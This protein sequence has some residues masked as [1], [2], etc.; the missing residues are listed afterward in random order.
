MGEGITLGITLGSV[1]PPDER[2]V[3]GQKG[4]PPQ[5]VWLGDFQQGQIQ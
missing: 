3:F 2:S 1:L 4:D 5:A